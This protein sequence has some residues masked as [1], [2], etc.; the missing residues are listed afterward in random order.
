MGV[1]IPFSVDLKLKQ[2]L[3][4]G[5]RKLENNTYDILASSGGRI[6]KRRRKDVQTV[7]EQCGE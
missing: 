2:T 5:I 1:E 4:L 7:G 6:K 3:F